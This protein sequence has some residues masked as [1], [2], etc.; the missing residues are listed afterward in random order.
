[1]KKL[2]VIAVCIVA[3]LVII[4]QLPVDLGGLM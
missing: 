3:C 4:F 2:H 1:M